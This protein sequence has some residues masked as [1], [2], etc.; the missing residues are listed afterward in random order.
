MK[1]TIAYG[2]YIA[3]LVPPPIPQTNYIL[4][5]PL[6]KPIASFTTFFTSTSSQSVLS[7]E[8]FT[9]HSSSIQA[10][11]AIYGTGDVF[12]LTTGRYRRYF[13]SIKEFGGGQIRAAEV[14][15]GGHF[16]IDARSKERIS[17]EIEAFIAPQSGYQ[18]REASVISPVSVSE[19]TVRFG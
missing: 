19:A 2:S 1:L 7:K 5:S 18:G 10:I 14:D 11:L 12:A 6:L 8:G 17:E 13:A 3:S 15:G 9:E 16:W 4:I